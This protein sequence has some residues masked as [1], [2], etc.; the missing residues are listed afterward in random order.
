MDS[1]DR[2]C[3]DGVASYADRLGSLGRMVAVLS[4]S[5]SLLLGIKYDS[6]RFIVI[7]LRL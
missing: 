5:E 3:P 4:A 2:G 1:Q 7:R 6:S